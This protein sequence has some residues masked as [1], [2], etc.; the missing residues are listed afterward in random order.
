M[1]SL[2]KNLP[3]LLVIIACLSFGASIPA[4]AQNPQKPD[5]PAVRLNLIVTDQSNHSLDEVRQEDVQI[6]ESKV[7]QTLSVFQKDERPVDYVIALDTSGSFKDM[8]GTAL[9][10]ARMVLDGN[11]QG[12]ETLLVSFISSD[13]INTVSDFTSDKSKL[14]DSLKRFKP[15]MGQSAVID[16]IYVAVKAAAEHNAADSTVRRA[17]I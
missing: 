12:D 1:E 3:V 9:D 7:P 6:I 14:I 15:G 11:R 4:Q 10:A 13:K 17:V 5:G 8:L 2:R 16:A